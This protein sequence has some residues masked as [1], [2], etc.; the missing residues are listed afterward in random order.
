MQG[1]ASDQATLFRWT[2]GT[3]VPANAGTVSYRYFTGADDVAYVVPVAAT[4][5][6]RTARFYL[7]GCDSTA[8]VEALLS[9]SSAAP[10]APID[11]TGG[12]GYYAVV[13]VEFRA[14]AATELRLKCSFVSRPNGNSSFIR[15][16][17]VTLQ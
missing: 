4:T 9:D 1:A 5:T 13:M 6:K 14:A 17:A 2:N 16:G 3:P 11:L 8:R 10:P 12:L 7:G 15:L